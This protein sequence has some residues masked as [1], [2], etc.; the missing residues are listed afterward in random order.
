[1]DCQLCHF[2]FHFYCALRAQI[3]VKL[4]LTD[5]QFHLLATQ[6][7]LPRNYVLCQSLM[8][9]IL[10]PFQVAWQSLLDEH[11]V[12]GFSFKFFTF[13]PTSAKILP[14]TRRQKARL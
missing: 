1:M 2:H 6:R 11:Q 14:V 4:R 5:R 8:T 7:N 12:S 3:T 13:K 10:K 9:T